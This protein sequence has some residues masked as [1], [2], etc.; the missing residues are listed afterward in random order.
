M[1]INGHKQRLKIITYAI[2]LP[3]KSSSVTFEFK[4]LTTEERVSPKTMKYTSISPKLLR[5]II[6]QI[7]KIELLLK[8]MYPISNKD[9]GLP[10]KKSFAAR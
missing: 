8:M 10:G 5:M 3:K 2:L 7:K 4:F 9:S 1:R 6:E